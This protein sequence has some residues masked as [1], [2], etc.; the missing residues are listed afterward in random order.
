MRVQDPFGFTKA[1]N[2]PK[3]KKT[4]DKVHK[5]LF[6]KEILSKPE[7]KKRNPHLSAEELELIWKRSIRG[8]N[9]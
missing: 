9:Y 3:D 2:F 7:L 1:I 8:I 6:K 4:V 5:L